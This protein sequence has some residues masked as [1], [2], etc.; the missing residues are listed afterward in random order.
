MLVLAARDRARVLSRACV[1]SLQVLVKKFLFKD[2]LDEAV[3]AL[4]EAVKKGSVSLEGGTFPPSAL[5][6]LKKHGVAEPHE[7]DETKPTIETTRRYRSNDKQNVQFYG[8]GG[9]FDYG[10]TVKTKPC[11]QCV[12]RQQLEAA[13][14]PA[15]GSVLLLPACSDGG[16]TCACLP[17][18]YYVR[19]LSLTASRALAY[20]HACVHVCVVV[21]QVRQ[22]SRGARHVRLVGPR[23]VEA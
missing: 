16:R 4:H 19:A 20:V 6:I 22:A 18:C 13:P 5:T 2:S 7:I 8:D 1:L 15:P 23:Q 17:H 14:S 11:K 3:H 12:W 9:G 21:G 10:K